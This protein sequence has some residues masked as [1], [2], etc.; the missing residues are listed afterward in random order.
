MNDKKNDLTKDE[1]AKQFVKSLGDLEN[2]NE[3]E[4]TIQDNKIKFKVNKINYRVRALTFEEDEELEKHRRTKYLE[5]LDDKSM[6]FQKTWLKI[7][8]EKGI[9][10]EGMETTIRENI[11]KEN[12]IMLK[13]AQIADKDRVEELKAE[14]IEIRTASALINIE[15]VDRMSFSI[16]DRLMVAVNSYY[17]YLALEKLEKKEWVRVYKNFQEFSKDRNNN[18][19]QTKAF[20][21]TNFIIYQSGV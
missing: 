19:L 14:I 1:L 5:F 8:L 16:E 15:K 3:I 7:Y 2:T 6:K 10:I 18:E 17:T 21:F 13:L 11:Q 9:D 12:Q 20:K 4:R